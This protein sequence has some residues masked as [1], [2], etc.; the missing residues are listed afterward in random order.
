MINKLFD[1]TNIESQVAQHI[2]TMY[3]CVISLIVGDSKKF[4]SD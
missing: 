4:E 1:V 2:S 3:P